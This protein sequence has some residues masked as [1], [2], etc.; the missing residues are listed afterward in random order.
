[1]AKVVIRTLD[2]KYAGGGREPELVDRIERAY[3]YDDGPETDAQLAAANT[4]LGCGWV[5]VDA[6]EECRRVRGQSR[7]GKEDSHG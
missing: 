7:E 5:K 2:G 3:L 4:L 6:E 1:M